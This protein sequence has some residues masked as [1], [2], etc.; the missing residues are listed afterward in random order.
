MESLYG[1]TLVDEHRPEAAWSKSKQILKRNR[2]PPLAV[3]ET[4]RRPLWLLP[5]PQRLSRTADNLP[6]YESRKPLRIEQGP[7]RLEGGWWDG[8][9]IGRDYYVATSTHGE[10]LW[11]FRDHRPDRD[12]YLHGFFS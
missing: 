7:E 11:I 2:R 1:M 10:R 12:W 4:P 5:A 8:H 9:D 6:C 3:G